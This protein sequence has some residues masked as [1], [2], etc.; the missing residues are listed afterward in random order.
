MRLGQLSRKI[1]TK[2]S[3]IIDYLKAAHQVDISNHP[4]SKVPEEYLSFIEKHFQ[5]SEIETSLPKESELN[6]ASDS[7]IAQ[8]DVAEE[9]TPVVEEAN[10]N[11]ITEE[12]ENQ[13]A[14]SLETVHETSE[15]EVELYIVDGVIKAPKLEVPGIKVVGKI[16]L[17]EPKVEEPEEVAQADA[18]TN[19][20]T[21]SLD[22]ETHADKTETESPIAP[23][24]EKR[25]RQPRDRKERSTS[26]QTTPKLTPEEE[27]RIQLKEAQKQ[28]QEQRKN[29]K[30]QRR[31]RYLQET[32]AKQKQASAKKLKKQ[33]LE[34]EARQKKQAKPK[35]TSLWGKFIYWLND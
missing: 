15:D 17:P 2:T 30:A 9:V 20:V 33:R 24:K 7:A 8:K 16:D 27:R 21:D 18:E 25:K 10:I 29:S 12:P 1:N 26:Q 3:E 32:K 6:T 11:D 23:V 22:S 5:P 35:P 34:K 4:N 19:E 14:P 13:E 31:E 28:Q